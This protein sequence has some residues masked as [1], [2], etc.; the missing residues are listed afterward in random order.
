MYVARQ[1]FSYTSRP[2]REIQ[3]A[4]YSKENTAR[5]YGVVIQPSGVKNKRSSQ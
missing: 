4:R 2:I 1:Y 5:G 3:A